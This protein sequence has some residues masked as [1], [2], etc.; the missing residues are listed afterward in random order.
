MALLTMYGIDVGID[1]SKL[2][3]LAWLVQELS[4]SYVPSSRPLIGKGAY[5]LESG[6]PTAWYRNV[7]E[8][9]RTTL[10]PVNPDFVGHKPPDI[11]MGK[12]SGRV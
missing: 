7:W 1:Y 8:T 5:S 11:L 2:N 4:G 10:F 6:I 3:E 12:K 9:N